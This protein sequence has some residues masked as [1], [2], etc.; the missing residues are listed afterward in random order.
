[1]VMGPKLSAHVGRGGLAKGRPR[2]TGAADLVAVTSTASSMQ[3]LFSVKDKSLYTRSW[4]P[5]GSAQDLWDE[6]YAVIN[7]RGEEVYRTPS[8]IEA[9][10]WIR[11]ATTRFFSGALNPS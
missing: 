7:F 8:R 9:E 1:M 4:D 2:A 11:A 6:D 3:K 10:R 5:D